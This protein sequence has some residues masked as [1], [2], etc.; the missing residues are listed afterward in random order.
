[1]TAVERLD[2]SAH[3]RLMAA[4]MEDPEFRAEYERT[5]REV[6][7]IDSI[8]RSL[9]SHRT[10]QGLSKA[11]LAR[12]VGRNPS[13]IRRLFTQETNPELKLVVSMLDALGLELSVVEQPKSGSRSRRATSAA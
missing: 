2:L 13:S 6:E 9:D 7:L 10:K 3:E 8:I 5:R 4:R 12:R 11:E 1:M